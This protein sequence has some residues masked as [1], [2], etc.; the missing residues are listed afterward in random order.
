MKQLFFS[1]IA[2]PAILCLA[3][4][5]GFG[6]LAFTQTLGTTGSF[7]N[8]NG[9]GGVTFNLQNT[10]SYPIIISEFRGVIGSGVTSPVSIYYNNTPVSGV[11]ATITVANGW[12]L[13]ASG[14]VAVVPNT[15][16]TTTQT[17]LTGLS[18][19]IPANTTYGILVYA[20]NQRYF[21][22]AAGTTTISQSGVNLITGTSIGYGGTG[23]PPVAPTITPRGWIGQIIFAPAIACSGNP[24]SGNAIASLGYACSGQPIGLSLANDSIRTGLKYQWLRSTNAAIGPYSII[25]NDTNRSTID[26]QTVTTWYRCL[27]SCGVTGLDTSTAVLVSTSSTPL[28]GNYTVDPGLP[29]SATNY[30]SLSNLA[31]EL[32]CVGVT[33]PVIIN[34]MASSPAFNEQMSFGNI[35]GTSTTNTVT[36]NGNGNTISTSLSP[37]VSFNG[38]KNFILDSL[39][40]IATGTTL[41]GFGIYLGNQAQNI[42][43]RKNRIDVGITSTAL[44]NAG[45][46]ISGSLT[47]ATTAGNNAQNIQIINNEVIGGYYGI[48]A[49]GNASYLNNSGHLI[50]NNTVSDFYIY[51]VYLNNAD[52]CLILNNDI[53]RLGRATVTTFYGIYLGTSKNIKVRNN[54]IRDAGIGAYTAYPIYVTVSANAVGFETE[55]INNAIYNINTTGLIYGMYFLGARTNIKVYHNTVA[56]VNNGTGAVRCFFASTVPDAHDLRNNIFSISGTGTGIK[57]VIYITTTAL[58]FTSNNNNFSIS[59]SVGTNS[60]G[61]WGANNTTLANWVS[62]SGQDLNSASALPLYANLATGN[63]TPGS[64]AIDNFGAPVG[65]TTDINGAVRSANTPDIGAV[66]FTTVACS[67]TPVAGQSV[68]SIP[69]ACSSVPFTLSLIND[70]LRSGLIYQWQSSLTG[71]SGSFSNIVGDTFRIVT[72]SQTV[73]KWYRCVVTCS[74]VNSDTSGIVAVSTGTIPLAGIYT[75]NPSL[76]NSAINYQ[77]ITALVSELNCVGISAPTTINIA[78]GSATIN[79]N[80]AFGII[81]GASSANTITINGNGNTILSSVSPLVSFSG[82]KFLT[83]D[84]LRIIGGASFSGFG[85]LFNNQSQN[86][87]INKCRVDVGVTSTLT[88]NAGIVVSSSTTA[89]TTV[90]NNAQ[91]IILTNNEIIGGYYGITLV[92]SA[93]YLNNSRHLVQNNIV[94]DFYFYGIYL[95]NADSVTILNNDVNRMNRPTLSTFYGIYLTTSRNIKIVNNRVHDAGVGAYTAYPIYVTISAN[96]VGFE[97]EFINNAVYNINTSGIIY[98][99]YLLGARSNLKIYHNTIALVS[100]GTGAIRCFF[101]STAPDGHDLKNNIFSI[102]GSGTGTK[103]CMYVTNVSASFTSNFNVLY[104]GATAGVNSVGFWALN[105]PT[106]ADWRTASGGDANSINANPVYANLAGGNF[107]PLS[108]NVDNIGTPLPAVS[109]DINGAAR[110]LTTPDVGSVEFSP[111]AGDIA[112]SKVELVRSDLCYS[113]NDT[114]KITLQNVIGAAVD[115]SVD[116]ITIIWSQSGPFAKTDSILVNSGILGIGSN[117]TFLAMNV[118]MSAPGFYTAN[119]FIRGSL[120]NTIS[121][122]D[123]LQMTIPIEVRAILSVS[124]KTRIV[125]SSTDTVTLEAFSPLFPGG[126]VFFSEIAHYKVATGAPLVGWP[127][128]LL[129]DDYVELTGIPNSSIAGFTMEEWT[130]T[131]L[132]YSV[133]FPTGVVFSPNG[134]MV[135]ATGQL[136]ASASSP[137]NFYYHTGNTVIHNSTGDN[138][139]YLIKNTSGVIVDATVYGTYS[140]PA[141]SGVTASIWSGNTPAISSSGNRL[142]APDNNTSTCWVNSGVTPQNPNV[143][144]SG[145]SLPTPGSMAGFNW[146]YLGAPIDTNAQIRVGPYTV[147]GIYWYVATYTT[148]CGTFRDTVT[149]TATSTVPVTLVSFNGQK[150]NEDVLLSWKTASEVNNDFFEVLV[151]ADGNAFEPIGIVKGSGNSSKENAYG[152][153]HESG[154]ISYPNNGVLYYK[155]AQHDFDGKINFTNTIRVD[156]TYEN[157]EYFNVL[158]NPNAGKFTLVSNRLLD[159]S[160][161]L[162]L[163]NGVGEVVW[164]MNEPITSETIQIELNLPT[165]IYFLQAKVDNK[166]VHTKI[167]IAK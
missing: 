70:T 33:G 113:T 55:F 64:S 8:N 76:P 86:I 12:N 61:Y 135:L 43:I 36:L 59:A 16:T 108:I 96:N 66:E 107:N 42:I 163:V 156:N 5:L 80:L 91:N 79:T 124:P 60:I 117:S 28:S 9:S 18:F 112:I 161:G 89:A 44:S 162:K 67:G 154:F 26:T 45:I 116:P 1:K 123:T 82:T 22:L 13:V 29:L 37:I 83:I 11:P 62:A 39:N 153:M 155:L 25:P 150:E 71:L 130:G 105:N 166:V 137:A 159:D 31:T 24:T 149:V 21:T 34:I 111:V 49:I 125:T 101:A 106:L 131:T 53:H 78:P 145:V 57:H 167:L 72:E 115:F 98:G 136:G 19:I 95:S 128:Y 119:A 65:V 4:I 141:A 20:L 139:G 146:S 74:V 46:A 93:S 151:S 6:N 2:K 160:K 88:T 104:M 75:I 157:E 144:N 14:S 164:Q 143:L 97:T 103:H 41:S 94:R 102:S 122:N 85:I 138:R 40:I 140:F 165:G 81:P 10:N 120:L 68:S 118:N 54:K 30:W 100:N 3:L 133:T 48:T 56:L 17:L 87:T 126:N 114:I 35:P 52:S 158:P 69:F 90:G 84:S 63:L 99:M 134:T 121:T 7:L 152:F 47:S 58:A 148:T 77:S 50:Q 38:T 129:A 142:N 110:S 23:I 27:V 127:A 147:P 73:S 132:Q 109:T 51:G 15:T 92:G 32:S